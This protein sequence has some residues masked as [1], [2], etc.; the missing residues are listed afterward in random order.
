MEFLKVKTEH[1]MWGSVILVNDIQTHKIRSSMHLNHEGWYWE[2]KMHRT[3]QTL[4][5][6]TPLI[7]SVWCYSL[8]PAYRQCSLH[9]SG[10]FSS[11][12]HSISWLQFSS[13]PSSFLLCCSRPHVVTYPPGSLHFLSSIFFLFHHLLSAPDFFFLLH[14]L[15]PLTWMSNL[16]PIFI[17]RLLSGMVFRT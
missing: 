6:T 16:G 8:L 1:S 2:K 17:L 7:P 4:W 15:N 9:L 13:L 14:N 3:V 12:F 5:T 10:A 11:D